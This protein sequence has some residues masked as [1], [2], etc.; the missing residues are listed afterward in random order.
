M[1]WL[2]LIVAGGAGYLWYTGGAST[3]DP[4]TAIKAGYTKLTGQLA[5]N[6]SPVAPANT[7][8]VSAPM[9]PPMPPTPNLTGAGVIKIGGV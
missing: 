4:V 1:K 5:P 7:S 9:A 2:L 3:S 8:T 6:A